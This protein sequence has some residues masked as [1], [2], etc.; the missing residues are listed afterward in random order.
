MSTERTPEQKA[1]FEKLKAAADALHDG[2]Q[3]FASL[4]SM[5]MLAILA[6]IDVFAVD[7]HWESTR[8]WLGTF[9]FDV[10]MD[11]ARGGANEVLNN[12]K[13]VQEH[14]DKSLETLK[15]D[16]EHARDFVTRFPKIVA[17]LPPE[18]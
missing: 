12:P 7:E 3:Q 8:N 16:L 1:R 9:L 18:S 10:L 6:L 13:W 2:L 11:V 15:D 17:E 14:L 5:D 4:E